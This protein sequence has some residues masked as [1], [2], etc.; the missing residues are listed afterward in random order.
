VAGGRQKQGSGG[1]FVFQEGVAGDWKNAF[2]EQAKQ[3]FK[4]VAG[5][6][7]IELGYERDNDW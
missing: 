4:A 6:L 5:D 1:P 2:T 7:L 3:D